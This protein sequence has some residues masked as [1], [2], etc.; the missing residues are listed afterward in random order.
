MA[1]S[2][3]GIKYDFIE[4]L[5]F[6]CTLKDSNVDGHGITFSLCHALLKKKAVLYPE[7]MLPKKFLM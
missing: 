2:N 6:F 7:I 5:N 4:Q 1:I 3:S